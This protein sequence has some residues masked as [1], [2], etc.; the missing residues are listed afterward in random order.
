MNSF[1]VNISNSLGEGYTDIKTQR[2]THISTS[3]QKQFQETRHVVAE[4][5]AWFKNYAAY[6]FKDDYVRSY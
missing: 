3:G 4:V 2:Y 1:Y 6:K 5:C